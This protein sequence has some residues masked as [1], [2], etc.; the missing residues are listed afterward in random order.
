MTVVATGFTTADVW[1]VVAI[2]LLLVVLVFLAVAEMGLSRITRARVTA[3]AETQGARAARL[4]KLVDEPERFVNP[5]LLTVN[6]CQTV[7]ATLTGI[8]AGRV[9]GVWGVVVGVVLNVIVFFVLAE[10]LPKT[11][12]ILNT[13]RAAL[14]AAR[15]VSALVA[16]APL[17]V[18]SRGLIGLTNWILPGK[19]LKQGPFVLE[20][21]EQELLAT[22]EA[23]AAE[24]VI[25]HEERELIESVIEFGDTVAREVMVHRTDMVTV[26]ADT[27]VSEAIDVLIHSGFSRAP[28]VGDTIDDVVGVAYARD[29]FKAE[30][31]QAGGMHVREFSRAARFFPETKPVADLMREMQKGTFHM[32]LLVDEYGGIAGLVTL[33]DLIEELVGDI[34]DEYDV[35]ESE[36]E[37]LGHQRFR[38]D[39]ALPVDELGELLHVSLPDDD[40]DTAGG[41]VFGLL[42]HVPAPGEVAEHEGWC[43]TVE[44]VEGRRITQL[45]VERAA[46]PAHPDA[47]V[48]DAA[49]SAA[50]PSDGAVAE[51]GTEPAGTERTAP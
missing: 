38:V 47:D 6:I 36:V 24:D 37:H 3:L 31:E 9:F 35:A 4:Q 11:W 28:V 27:T 42:G 21:A 33:E 41:F 32:A 22:I 18:A 29:L 7:Q 46:E 19:G 45:L 30:R 8:V 49:A 51:G 34:V 14:F 48:V 13:E 26:Q 12:A 20:I 43:F 5:I 50:R 40:W 25:E 23:A 16:F 10:S 15:P 2:A 39:A 1:M 44:Q 17:R